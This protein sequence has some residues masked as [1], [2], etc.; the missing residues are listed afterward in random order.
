MDRGPCRPRARRAAQRRH[1]GPGALGGSDR[2]RRPSR[3]HRRRP[4]GR[5]ERHRHG[6][7]HR[8][9]TWLRSS[10]NGPCCASERTLVLVSTDAGAY[11]GA[12]RG[13]SR[14]PRPRGHRDRGDRPRR[15][16]PAQG[17]VHRD[18]RR[19]A[20]V[21]GAQAVRT[22][23]AR[24]SRDGATSGT[25]LGGHAARGARRSLRRRGAGPARPRPVRRHDRR[26]GPP[27][28]ND[29][30]TQAVVGGLGRATEALRS[31][32]RRER[33]GRVSTP[34]SLFL[35][36]RA[37]SGWAVRLTLVVAVVPFVLGIVD[38]LVRGRRRGL[39]SGRPSEGSERGSCSGSTAGFSSASAR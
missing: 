22:A 7:A 36:D 19:P 30:R 17:P 26:A 27:A 28:G 2:S 8:A 14:R 16:R 9:R 23:A 20:R 31:P 37:A 10:V 33:R 32:D 15:L 13:T 24:G 1:G 25:A 29:G 21:A 5:R 6:G 4:G 34:D 11:G 35:D 12:G 39:R 18:R 3:Q 38:L